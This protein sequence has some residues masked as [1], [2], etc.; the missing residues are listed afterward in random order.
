M[1]SP[2]VSLRLQLERGQHGLGPGALAPLKALGAAF[3]DWTLS[4]PTAFRLTS[5]RRLYRFDRSQRLRAQFAALRSHT[6][7]RVQQAQA[8]GY[9]AGL[10]PGQLALGLRAMAY[11]LV[12]MQIDGQ[13]PQWGV[14]AAQVRPTLQATLA[15]LID[16][17]A[18]APPALPLR[19]KEAKS[20]GAF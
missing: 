9:F 14:A 10:A 16:N 2:Q 3:L 4:H 5:A 17:L 8:A 19:K 7:E 6:L 11:G 12:R 1:P 13:L 20:A 15:Q 18:G